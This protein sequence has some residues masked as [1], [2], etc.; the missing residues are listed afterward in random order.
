MKLAYKR[1][2]HVIRN[3]VPIILQRLKICLH[4]REEVRQEI[5]RRVLEIKEAFDGR[6]G[7]DD[8]ISVTTPR[9]GDTP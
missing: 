5:E 8:A 6:T 4:C 1:L 3:N 7:D 9:S 2:S